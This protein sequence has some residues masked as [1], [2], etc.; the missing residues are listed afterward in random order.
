MTYKDCILVVEDDKSIQKFFSLALITHGYQPIIASSGIE[1]INL[2]MSH[3]PQV[4][5]LDLG[6]PDIDGMEVLKT[7]RLQG[8]TPVIVVSARGKE[9]EKVLALDSGADDFVTKPFNINEVLARIRVVQRKNQTKV[10]TS[11][12]EYKGLKVDFDRHQVFVDNIEVHLTPLEFKLLS[13]L[14][15]YQGKVL[16]HAFI[17]K[18]IWGYETMDDYQSLRVFMAS[19]RKKIE[20]SANECKFILTEVGVGYRLIDE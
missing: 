1:A 19:I 18:N 6:L 16:T 11:Q 14:V 2:F 17:Q 15:E 12:F 8:S 13:L 9:Q 3:Q 7:I 20:H 5:L 10:P 4:V